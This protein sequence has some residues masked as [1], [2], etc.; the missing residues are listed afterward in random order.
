MFIIGN[1][2]VAIAKIID[3]VFVGIV[4]NLLMWA[5]IIRALLSWVN[6]DPYNPIVQTLNRITE[7]ILSPI[8]RKLP[9]ANMGIDLSVMVVIMVIILLQIFLRSFLVQSLFQLADAM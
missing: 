3:V 5:F 9:M 4:L 6:P 1:F 8:R 7:P 2:I